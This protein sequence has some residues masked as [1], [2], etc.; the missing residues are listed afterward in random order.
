MD[1]LKLIQ[2]GKIKR[3]F[4]AKGKIAYPG[5]CCHVTQRAP[6]REMLF[7]ENSDYLFM[8]KLLKEKSKRFLFDVYSFVL[9]PN[10]VH[11][12]LR[13]KEGNL[14][15]SMKSLFQ[16]YAR[17]FNAKYERKGHVFCGAYREALCLDDGYALAT[18]V[19]IHLNPV[20]A[21]L[22]GDPYRYR[23]S[24]CGLYAAGNKVASFVD[25]KF[26]LGLLSKDQ[27]V[28][29]ENYRQLLARA[30]FIRTSEVWEKP[31]ILNSFK[32]ELISLLSGLPALKKQNDILD[33]NALD[34][35]IAELKEKGRLR[36]PQDL[37]ARKYLIEQLKARGFG[38]TEIA[39]KLKISRQTV[40]T[41][42][43]SPDTKSSHP[44]HP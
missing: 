32:A 13:L 42:L 15:E 31:G 12:Q 11:L 7:L 27:A 16:E 30:A 1:I 43:S 8:L 24:S 5:A 33:E 36:L 25:E 19:Y 3:V 17:F 2:E 39:G 21:A 29:R 40:Y 41:T 20:R 10:H 6:G 4:R 35:K 9:M 38:L 23:W 44:S 18:S 28:A 26:I 14:S 34:K 37:K 22:A